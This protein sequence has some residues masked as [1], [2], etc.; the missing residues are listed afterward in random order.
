MQ[1]QDWEAEC[2][3]PLGDP[4][5]PNTAVQMQVIPHLVKQRDGEDSRR[6]ARGNFVQSDPP[7]FVEV[8]NFCRD[9][10]N[11]PLA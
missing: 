2:P 8:L 1:S 7:V 5:S 9:D 3:E 10:L 4:A 6:E 11:F